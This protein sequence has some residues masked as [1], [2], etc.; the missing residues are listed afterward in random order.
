MSLGHSASWR[1]RSQGIH[2]R[3]F[4]AL[5]KNSSVWLPEAGPHLTKAHISL[6]SLGQE[7]VNGDAVTGTKALPGRE[8]KG[9]RVWDLCSVSPLPRWGSL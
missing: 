3:L 1:V 9:W 2:L 4:V 5:V 6:C 8:G 7:D